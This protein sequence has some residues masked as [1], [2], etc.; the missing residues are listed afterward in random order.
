MR[1]DRF[2]KPVGS[3]EW[4]IF[5]QFQPFL[6]EKSHLPPIFRI[7]CLDNYTIPTLVSVDKCQ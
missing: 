6:S 5:S 3:G 7:I 4:Y 2:Q 1:P